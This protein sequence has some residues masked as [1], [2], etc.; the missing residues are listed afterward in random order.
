MEG[1]DGRLSCPTAQTIPS[2]TSVVVGSPGGAHGQRPFGRGLVEAGLGHLAPEADALP[3]PEILRSRMEVGQQV[4]LGREAGDP[5]VRLREGEAVELVGH[6]DPAA[7]VHVLEPRPAH[8]GVLLEHRDRHA[9]LAQAVRRR[10]AGSARAHD[11]APE[12]ASEVRRVPGGPARVGA[13][14]REL[15]AQE[16][17]PVLGRAGTDQE[18]EDAPAFLRCQ[19][20]IRPARSQVIRKGGG[21][22]RTRLGHPLWTEAAPGHKQLSL[23]RREFLPQQRQVARA[24]RH[25]AEQR[26][27][28]RRGTGRRDQSRFIPTHGT[29]LRR[30]VP[31][32]GQ[33]PM[34]LPSSA[35]WLFT[36]TVRGSLSM[37]VARLSAVQRSS[38]ST[39]SAIDQPA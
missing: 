10:Q 14:E 7:R 31:P 21:R 17:L 26:M 15:L 33:W 6:V 4:G 23:V 38:V 32:G 35:I 25:R 37:A 12:L 30:R 16:S 28:V 39:E 5:V 20:M 2:T 19:A 1:K 34:C 24:V 11:G 8:V 22:Q 13:F 36:S 3:Q 18:P 29:S 27:H 9:G